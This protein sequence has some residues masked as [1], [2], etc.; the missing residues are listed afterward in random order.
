[1]RISDVSRL[2]AH[3]Q[4]AN[5]VR[6][7]IRVRFCVTLHHH[8]K[9][10]QDAFASPPNFLPFATAFWIS[11]FPLPT[12]AELYICWCAYA[13]THVIQRR[14][15]K[16]LQNNFQIAHFIHYVLQNSYFWSSAILLF[17]KQN[18]DQCF[19]ILFL[20]GTI[21]HYGKSLKLFP[22]EHSTDI[23]GT[24]GAHSKSSSLLKAA[25][26]FPLALHQGPSFAPKA[27][28]QTLL[29]EHVCPWVVGSGE[30]LRHTTALQ[31]TFFPVQWLTQELGGGENKSV[32]I[33]AKQHFS[34]FSWQEI[35]KLT[36]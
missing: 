10:P 31:I 15:K 9:G 35:I 28:V 30:C 19:I 5:N 25:S 27:A 34:M 16:S 20:K 32:C 29:G 8:C 2:S 22:Q 1:M 11:Q 4:Q 14:K 13:Y 26:Q 12:A 33:D 36:S 3:H 18:Q 23:D 7:A 17:A 21:Q 6:Q 24:T